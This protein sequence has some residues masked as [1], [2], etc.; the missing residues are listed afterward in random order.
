MLGRSED[1]DI[2]YENMNVLAVTKE[3]GAKTAEL[4]LEDVGNGGTKTAELR[5]E[6]VDNG[7]VTT[8]EGRFGRQKKGRK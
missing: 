4:R 3:G 6:D 8:A 7:G 1:V 5:P 2:A